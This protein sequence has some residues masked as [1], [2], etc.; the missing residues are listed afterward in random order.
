MSNCSGCG[1][2][3]QN[4]DVNK[5]GY[6]TN[7]ENDLCERCFRIKHY[8]TYQKIEKTNEDFRPII[9]EINNSNDLAVVLIDLMNVP[10]DLENFI[11]SFK[12]QV[13][14]VLTKRDLM[15]KS[16]Y[17]ERIIERF[18]N[19]SNNIL[20]TIIIS[21][22]KNYN[23]DFLMDKIN[24]YKKTKNVYIVGYT[25]AGKSSLVNK[26]I[27]NYT[28]QKSAITTSILPTTTIRNINIEINDDLLLID[29]P[30]LIEEGNIVDFVGHDLLEKIIPKREIKPITYQLKGRQFVVID[31]LLYVE[32][33]NENDVTIY[34]SNELDIMR[35]WKEQN[36]EAL[37]EHI[38][39][40]FPREDIVVAGLCFIKTMKKDRVR[41]YT[42][43]G[44]KVYKRNALI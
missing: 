38:L 39:E 24:E 34:I 26:I 15:P 23:I 9:D 31:K 20:E 18:S 37:E 25:N 28:N 6:A 27:Y 41:I 16:L 8:N 44:V 7:L 1:S 33:S 3:K 10:F 2:V 13:L 29:T 12:N 42:I 11:N 4:E 43:P 5:E 22:L 40:V 17:D 32:F 21:S 14:L 36:L 35:S 30:G 19:L